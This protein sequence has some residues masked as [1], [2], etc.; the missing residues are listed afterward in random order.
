[1]SIETNL[2]RIA[3]ALEAMSNNAALIGAKATG[4]PLPTL[5]PDGAVLPPVVADSVVPPAK[6][7]SI[8]APPAVDTRRPQQKAADTRR[9]NKLRKD[10]ERNLTD[11]VTPISTPPP[12]TVVSPEPAIASGLQPYAVPADAGEL[13]LCANHAAGVLGPRI[14]A[15]GDL[16][17]GTYHVSSLSD[18]PL[19]KYAGFVRDLYDLTTKGAA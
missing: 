19:E 14:N 4:M 8:T 15:I 7:E 13:K 18:L 11:N 2:E 12:S 17:A 1:M 6:P 3:N 9:A 16:L 10:E 5:A